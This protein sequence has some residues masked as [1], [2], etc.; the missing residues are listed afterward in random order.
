MYWPARKAKF[1]LAGSLSSIRITSSARRSS[2]CTR[3]GSF[4]TWMSPARVTLRA[5]TTR[6][7]S[8]FAQ[9][10]RARPSARSASLSAPGE[11]SPCSTSPSSTRP[12]QAPQAPSRQPC[13]SSR[14]AASAASSTVWSS[15]AWKEW[16]P[17]WREI[18]WLMVR[19][20]IKR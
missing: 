13:G 16:L 19:E 14:P 20:I 5:C 8:G 9:Q 12:L 6:S 3:Q 15:S 2:F 10:N 7:P 18:R 11:C 1:S 17:G 4:L